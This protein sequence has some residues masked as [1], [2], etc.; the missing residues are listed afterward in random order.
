[1]SE[2]KELLL[3]EWEKERNTLNSLSIKDKDQSNAYSIQAERVEHLEKLLVDLDKKELEVEAKAAE[4]DINENARVEQQKV[5]C[6]NQRNR[7]I[8]EA[9]KIGVPVVAAFAMG[10][11]S[12]KWEKLD[13]LTSTAGK[14]A[15]REI[16]RFK[17]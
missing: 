16:L 3:T 8:I 2:M 13:T 14:S 6:K 10:V 17:N 9:C 12:M 11:I 4:I 5:E 15:L 7:N 1:M